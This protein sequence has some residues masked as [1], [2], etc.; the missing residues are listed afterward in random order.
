[1]SWLSLAV[2]LIYAG[3]SSPL[4]MVIPSINFDDSWIAAMN[5][6]PFCKYIA[7]GVKIDPKSARERQPRRQGQIVQFKQSLDAWTELMA[8]VSATESLIRNEG[9]HLNTY[10]ELQTKFDE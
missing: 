5:F 2:L 3:I 7:G 6:L 9:Y 4:T 8:F 1:M 10:E